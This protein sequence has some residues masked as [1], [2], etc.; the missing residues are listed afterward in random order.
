[1]QI[2]KLLKILDKYSDYLIFAIATAGMFGSLYF[3]EVIRYPVC[4]L[5]W[6]QRILMYPLVVIFAVAILRKERTA[7]YYGLPL[8]VIGLP[9]A[10]YQ[11]LLQWGIVKEE[12]INCTL[13]SNVSC[14]EAN[15]NILSF[16][17]IPF[18]SFVAFLVIFVLMILRIYLLK[19]AS[20][21]N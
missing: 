4:L 5:C 8:V 6:W 3:S 9:M 11:S 12:V 21:K 10:F 18:L 14:G 15:F 1:M 20:P 13:T 7:I 16:I 19:K 2:K 17:N